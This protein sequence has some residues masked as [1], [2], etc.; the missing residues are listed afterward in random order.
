MEKIIFLT[1]FFLNHPFFF[2][3]YSPYNHL[4]SSSSSSLCFL[5]EMMPGDYI[6][7]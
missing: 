4:S 6:T 1:F 3:T 2:L 5:F 7:K